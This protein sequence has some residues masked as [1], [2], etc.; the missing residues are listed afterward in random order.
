MLHRHINDTQP[1]S[2]VAIDDIISRGSL[3]DWIELRDALIAN[4]DLA[5]SIQRVCANYIHDPTEQR[6]HFWNFFVG[7]CA[8]SEVSSLVSGTGCGASAPG[9]R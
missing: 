8:S 6:Y 2:L 4:P 7:S 1:F 3:A 9:N 5:A